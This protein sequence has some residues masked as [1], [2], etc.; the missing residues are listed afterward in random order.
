MT[1]D[2]AQLRQWLE[3]RR[4]KA[5]GK[6]RTGEKVA[7]DYGFNGFLKRAEAEHDTLNEVLDKLKELESK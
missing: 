2:T 5:A 3:D 7:S 6:V 1:I 4:D